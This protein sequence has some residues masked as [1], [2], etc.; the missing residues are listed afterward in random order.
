VYISD[1]LSP[2]LRRPLGQE[3][4]RFPADLPLSELERRLG[5]RLQTEYELTDVTVSIDTRGRATVSGAPPAGGFSR[6]IPSGHRAVSISALV[7]TGFARWD[8]VTIRT[9]D[10]A[11]EGTIVSARSDSTAASPVVDPVVTDGGSEIE[12]IGLE[13]PLAPTTVGGEGRV[14]MAVSRT[15]AATLLQADRGRILVQSRGT[16]R[17][18]ELVSLFRRAGA[19]IRRTT[20][21]TGGALDGTTLAEAHVRETYEIAVLAVRQAPHVGAE[22]S[23]RQWMFSPRGQTALSAGDEL[24][25]VGAPSALDR[26][27]EAIA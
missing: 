1:S 17:E 13:T 12:E 15:D 11:V 27:E 26:F 25:V 4:S 18:F 24:F 9:D 5:E 8:E 19:R 23:D 7:P 2:D 3:S 20:V 6:R 16:R 22:E 10:G 14:T 21:P